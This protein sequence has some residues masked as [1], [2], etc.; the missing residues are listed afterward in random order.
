MMLLM[1]L[2]CKFFGFPLAQDV[3]S[4]LT[5]KKVKRNIAVL[6]TTQKVEV[7]PRLK[8]NKRPE[9]GSKLFG[10]ILE[11]YICAKLPIS[12]NDTNQCSFD[13]NQI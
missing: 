1:C 3:C 5:E 11:F 8:V 4:V 7:V 12:S 10:L 13:D 6:C 9:A 2:A